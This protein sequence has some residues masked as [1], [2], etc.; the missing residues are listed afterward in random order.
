V[1]QVKSRHVGSRRSGVTPARLKDLRRWNLGL[2]VLHTVQAALILLMASDFAITVTTTYPQG[3]PG[4]RLTTPEGL[5]DVRIG[6]AIA[7]FL[8]ITW[9]PPRSRAVPTKLILAEASTG[10]VGLSTRSAPR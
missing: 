4:T 1:N 7:V 2:T 10:F 8:L 3:P 9:S 6:P 5:F